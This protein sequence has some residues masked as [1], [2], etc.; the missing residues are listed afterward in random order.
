MASAIPD[1]LAFV[2]VVRSVDI[3]EQGH[4]LRTACTELDRFAGLSLRDSPDLGIAE[5]PVLDLPYDVR[6]SPPRI[7]LV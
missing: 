4:H 6:P 7:N 3:Q 5:R 2:L 1:N